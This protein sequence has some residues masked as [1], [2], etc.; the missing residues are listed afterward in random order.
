MTAP[1]GAAFAVVVAFV[2]ATAEGEPRKSYLDEPYP[3]HLP[4]KVL[5]AQQLRCLTL[6]LL[7]VSAVRAAAGGAEKYAN[8]G[9]GKEGQ[10]LGCSLICSKNIHL[11][12]WMPG[13]GGVI[14]LFLSLLLWGV[15]IILVFRQL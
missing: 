3:Q 4:D 9:A 2:D 10:G 13:Y 8:P 15:E 11:C 1:G 14:F 6:A 12:H 7:E 5:L